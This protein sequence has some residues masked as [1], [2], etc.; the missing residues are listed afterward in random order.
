MLSQQ[1]S[2]FLNSTTIWM[3]TTGQAWG[4]ELGRGIVGSN[5]TTYMK[6]SYTLLVTIKENREQNGLKE[7]EEAL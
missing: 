3:T 4:K 1:D 2:L 7:I 6:M 5:G